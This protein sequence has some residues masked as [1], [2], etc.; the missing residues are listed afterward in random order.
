LI[1]VEGARYSR[2]LKLLLHSGRPVLIQ[3]RPWREWYW[4]ELVP[5]ENYIPVERDLSDLLQRARWVRDNPQAAAQIGR[6]SQDMAQRVLTRNSAVEQWAA[7]LS[8][9]AQTPPDAWAS[10]AL[11]EALSPDVRHFPIHR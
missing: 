9:T 7:T 5:W 1:D 2:R 8:S 3:D 10:L 11:V 4:H 6:A